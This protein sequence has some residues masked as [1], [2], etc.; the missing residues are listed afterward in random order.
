MAASGVGLAFRRSEILLLSTGTTWKFVGKSVGP[1][2]RL[3]KFSL[4][5]WAR[6]ANKSGKVVHVN[7]LINAVFESPGVIRP[8]PAGVMAG[9]VA[10]KWCR[11]G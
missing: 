6:L 2:M 11:F 7:Q 1:A 5:L 8:T 10:N 9:L 3:Q 4:A